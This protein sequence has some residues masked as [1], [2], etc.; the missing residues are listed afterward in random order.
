VSIEFLSVD[1]MWYMVGNQEIPIVCVTRQRHLQRLRDHARQI[2][3]NVE[4]RR[5]LVLE[6]AL[7]RMIARRRAQ[8]AQRVVQQ[9]LDD[10]AEGAR[11]APLARGVLLTMMV[12][13]ML[14][15]VE[16]EDRLGAFQRVV[17]EAT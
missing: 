16:P 8:E 1:Q 9:Q 10:A 5:F 11:M 7:R 6:E 4:L 13:A 12:M 17:R 3:D 2:R 14:P 15:P